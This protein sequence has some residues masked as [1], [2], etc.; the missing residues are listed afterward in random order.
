MGSVCSSPEAL[1]P[2][3]ALTVARPQWSACAAFQQLA[4][5]ARTHDAH[6]TRAPRAACT[7][8]A[9]RPARHARP[10]CSSGRRTFAELARSAP[11]R[12]SSTARR[13]HSLRSARDACIICL[14]YAR[15]RGNRG[16]RGARTCTSNRIRYTQDINGLRWTFGSLPCSPRGTRRGRAVTIRL[17]RVHND[18]Q[19]IRHEQHGQTPFSSLLSTRTRA[20]A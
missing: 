13:L 8:R 4:Q 19:R 10:M 15:D 18:A 3:R 5:H 6:T 12:S 14:R 17:A 20:Q 2:A 9:R 11:C 16:Q 7:T 1:R